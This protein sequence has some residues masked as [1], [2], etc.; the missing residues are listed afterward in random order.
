MTALLCP[1][2]RLRCQDTQPDQPAEVS[3][4]PACSTP[5]RRVE[6][7]PPDLAGA[8]ATVLTSALGAV[9]VLLALVAWICVWGGLH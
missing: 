9:L 6:V 7:P 4:C 3:R 8:L 2:C 1:T 5:L